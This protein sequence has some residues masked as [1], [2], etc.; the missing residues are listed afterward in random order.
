[1]TDETDPPRVSSPLAAALAAAQLEL[2]DPERSRTVNVRG[3]EGR[4]GYSYSYATLA[5]L[6]AAV[7]PVLGRHGLA[8]TSRV[9]PQP[10]GQ[11]CVVELLHAGG[12]VLTSSW[13]LTWRGGPQDRGSELT[14]ARRYL[15]EGLV[16]VAPTDGDDDGAAAQDRREDRSAR[17]PERA[18]EPREDRPAREDPEPIPWGDAEI[19]AW[20]EALA[21]HGLTLDDVSWYAVEHLDRDPPAQTAD[22]AARSRA[23]AWFVEHHADVT[24]RLDDLRDQWRRAFFAKWEVEFPTPR[25]SD[26]GSDEDR[27]RIVEIN[28]GHRRKMLETWYGSGVDSHRLI[29]VRALVQGEWSIDRIR[30]MSQKDFADA[31]NAAIVPF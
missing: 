27:A 1:M 15:I 28:E 11:V 10:E 25:K 19:A 7:R 23:L 17:E 21:P 4:A 13:P 30:A 16:G 29:P 5:D 6:L 12:E 9:V 24:A 22:K 14:Y 3:K 18:R 2:R 26:G 31:V 8:V 20:T